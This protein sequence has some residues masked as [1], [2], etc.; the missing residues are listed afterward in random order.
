MLPT[1]TEK[2]NQAR[3][4]QNG[5]K[6]VVN[7]NKRSQRESN[8]QSTQKAYKPY[9]QLLQH[10]EN[11]DHNIAI[12]IHKNVS[13]KTARAD[14]ESLRVPPESLSMARCSICCFF[15]TFFLLGRLV[16]RRALVCDATRRTCI[17][18]SARHA[19]KRAKW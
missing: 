12:A 15:V 18:T 8:R 9:G 19:L 1:K 16:A 4:L 11:S 10:K 13:V 7:A 5:L 6:R 2:A 3:Y 17:T 14:T